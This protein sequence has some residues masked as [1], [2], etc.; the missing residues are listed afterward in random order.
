MSSQHAH[1]DHHHHGHHSHE[2]TD[3]HMSNEELDRMAENYDAWKA[4]KA[5]AERVVG[6]LR[7]L[8]CLEPEMAILDFGCG[9]GH[10]SIPLALD[11]EFCPASVLGMDIS[12]GMVNI[13][14]KKAA[15][16]GVE[17]TCSALVS[18]IDAHELDT[19][20]S[21]YALVLIPFVL[22]HV[23]PSALASVTQRL[24]AAA[25]PGAVIAIADWQS[26]QASLQPF[27]DVL[28]EFHVLCWE[29]IHEVPEQ[30][31]TGILKVQLTLFRKTA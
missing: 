27:R 13:F 11:P 23:D 5:M 28:Q 25:K 17:K 3:P 2:H 15:A 26:E 20:R 31:K 8:K 14:N 30:S 10:Y 16:A 18:S 22:H 24:I 4:P 7:E 21:T 1:H 19:S 12:P 9:T 6:T 29:E